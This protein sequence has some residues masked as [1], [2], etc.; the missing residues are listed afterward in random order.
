MF[1]FVRL[2]YKFLHQFHRAFCLLSLKFR[3]I[4]NQAECFLLAQNLGFLLMIAG[5]SSFTLCSS[6]LLFEML[7]GFLSENAN[8]PSS[9]RR[10]VALSFRLYRGFVPSRSHQLPIAR[11]DED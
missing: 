5:S 7:S 1:I 9:V 6:L 4:P 10:L 11:S 2:R 3:S 8:G